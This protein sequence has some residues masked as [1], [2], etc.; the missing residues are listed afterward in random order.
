MK[1]VI[2]RSKGKIE[3]VAENNL[4]LKVFTFVDESEIKEALD[5]FIKVLIYEGYVF[6]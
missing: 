6:L 5:K 4:L 1:A 3:I 2:Y